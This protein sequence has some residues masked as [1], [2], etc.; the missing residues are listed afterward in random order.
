MPNVLNTDKQIAIVG[1]LAEGSSIRSIE[2][3]SG[4]QEPWPEQRKPG[5]REGRSCQ[6]AMRKRVICACGW[7]PASYGQSR[8]LQGPAAKPSQNG[9]E[10]R[11][12]PHR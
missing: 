8:R 7:R 3:S 6:R 2:R 11:S 10:A 1:Q 5:N 12:M 4:V 9:W